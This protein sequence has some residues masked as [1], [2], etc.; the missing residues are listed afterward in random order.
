MYGAASGIRFGRSTPAGSGCL[1]RNPT[2]RPVATNTPNLMSF[3]EFSLR[4][5][6]VR[7]ASLQHGLVQGD[8]RGARQAAED[9]QVDQP[10]GAGEHA[11]LDRTEPRR[12]PVSRHDDDVE[13]EQ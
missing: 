12:A 9:E 6:R 2:R 1:A 4:V 10:D 5:M 3:T 8:Q 11:D 7:L 13:I